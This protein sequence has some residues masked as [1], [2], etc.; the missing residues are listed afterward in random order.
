[1]QDLDNGKRPAVDERYIRPKAANELM[2]AAQNIRQTVYICGVTGYGKT[3][4]VADYLSR[5]KYEYYSM[6][7]TSILD[8]AL[9]EDRKEKAGQERIIV[10][11]DLHQITEPEGRKIALR[12]L[13]KLAGDHGTWLIL[14]SRC[15]LPAWLKSLYIQRVF[16]TIGERELSFSEKEEEAYL[17]K[18]DL[19]LSQK[20]AGR[21][22]ELGAGH[23]LFLRIQ[24]IRLMELSDNG[25]RR[26]GY[27]EKELSIIEA[28]RKDWWDYLETHVYDQWNVELQEFLMD[29]SIIEQF[30]LQ[31]AQLITKKNDAGKIILLAQETGN[32]LIEHTKGDSVVYELRNPM[33]LCM[34]RW[35][36]KRCTQTHIDGLY[37]SAGNSYEMQ[38][39][40]PEALAMYEKCCNE[41]GIS[42][43]LIENARRNPGSGYYWEL[44]RYYLALSEE[45]IRQSA[46]LLAGM[47]L[48]QSILLNDEESEKWYQALVEYAK[49]QTGSAKKAAQ[50]RL[51][52]LDIALPQRGTGQMTDVIKDAWRFV[53][54]R[55]TILPELSLTNNQPSMM[56]G[57]KDFCEWSK[58]DRELAKSIGKI[59]EKLLGSF[60]KGLVDLALAESFF[61]KGGDNYEVCTL[62]QKGRLQAQAGGK[63]EQVFVA[64]GILAQL[65]VMNNHMEDAMENLEGFRTSAAAEAPQLLTSIDTLR[66]RF[67]L[68]S[69]RSAEVAD[70][71][72][73][74]PDEAA[75]FCTLERYRY[76][77]KV[78]VYLSTGRRE[79]AL[80]LLLQ[81]LLYAEKRQRTYLQTEAGILLAITQFRM[82][83][84]KWQES[85]QHAVTQAEGYHFVR[86]LT[87]EGAAL[88]ELLKAG[89]FTWQ[90]ADFKRQ[91]FKECEQMAQ[92]YP[93]YLSEKQEGNVSLTD[94]ALKILRLQAEGLSVEQI[95]YH[96]GLSKAGVKYY[97]RETYKKLGVSGKAAAITEARNRRLI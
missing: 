79:K 27:M 1:M 89:D 18:W 5:R 60:G 78:R 93:V 54:E 33:K 41:E 24:A 34:R 48:L 12:I 37:Y 73:R 94:K 13:E 25:K 68:Y 83:E 9:P 40:I 74:A 10:V 69:G 43:L 38:G 20:A 90:D 8:V 65:S 75:E 57:G 32:F 19:M 66:T 4:F 3:S 55:K 87:R 46:E 50:S 92:L 2:K 17:G 44:R 11:D 61:E 15:L 58:R 6:N 76:I 51:F 47:S 53:T 31:M 59:V 22:R 23:P 30:D 97:N 96:L 7:N 26:A 29:I 84:K 63:P 64:V 16:V 95:A 80:N 88:W 62:A 56:H 21:L 14:I 77:T 52:Y 82:G 39:R 42:R 35:L 86:I 49:T 81:L 91:V 36:R 71:M 70:W 45:T 28:T 85:L 67:L 72:E